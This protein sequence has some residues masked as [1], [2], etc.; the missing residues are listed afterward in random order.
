MK[1]NLLAITVS[2]AATQT[3]EAQ[4]VFWDPGV[5]G[6]GHYYGDGMVDAADLA[7]LLGAWGPCE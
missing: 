5:G 2:L 4:V 6:N 3:S 1:R 7:Q